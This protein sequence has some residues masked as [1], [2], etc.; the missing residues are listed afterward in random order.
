MLNL[1]RLTTW[2]FKMFVLH[3]LFC[4]SKDGWRE[5]QRRAQ[6]RGWSGG[7]RPDNASGFPAPHTNDLCKVHIYIYIHMY[8]CVCV[9]EIYVVY[10]YIY[11]DVYVCVRYMPCIYIYTYIQTPSFYICIHVFNHSMHTNHKNSTNDIKTITIVM[12]IVTIMTK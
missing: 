10:I 6:D 5:R 1:N 9:C 2:S 8:M 12:T 11:I 7:G 3:H 4:R